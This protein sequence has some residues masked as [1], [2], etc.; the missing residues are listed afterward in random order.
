MLGKLKVAELLFE[1]PKDYS[2]PDVGTL[3]VFARSVEKVEKPVDPD[4]EKSKQLPWRK[5]CIYVSV[6]YIIGLQLSLS[7]LAPR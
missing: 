1:V 2:K 6:F 5:N 3:R 7:A 4:E